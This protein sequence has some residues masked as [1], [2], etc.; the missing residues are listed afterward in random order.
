MKELKLSDILQGMPGVSLVEGANLH[1]CC[2][3]ELHRHGHTSPT[4]MKVSS[5]DD[6]DYNLLWND[7]FDNQLDRTYSDR[8]Y[9]IERSAVCISI[10]LALH[11]TDYTVIERSRKG[12]GFDYMLGYKEDV[13]YN[14]RARL[15][16]SGISKETRS[17]SMNMRFEQKSRQTDISDSTNLPAYISIVELQTPKA[18]FEPKT[19]M[20]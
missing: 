10:I 3:V 11:L 15:E 4:I 1:E 2:V 6:I 9:S 17:N 16:I 8:Q 20:I 13:F 19:P 18:I 5:E 12:T 7:V 14:P